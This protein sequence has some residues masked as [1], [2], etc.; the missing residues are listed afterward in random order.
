MIVREGIV[1]EAAF[2]RR[3][4]EAPGKRPGLVRLQLDEAPGQ[5]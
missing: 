2:Q 1:E 3:Q 5:N 4:I